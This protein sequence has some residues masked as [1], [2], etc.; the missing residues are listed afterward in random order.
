MPVT[1]EDIIAC[2]KR[3][4]DEGNLKAAR[5]QLGLLLGIDSADVEKSDNP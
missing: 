2:I 3:L 5:N 1:D 4:I